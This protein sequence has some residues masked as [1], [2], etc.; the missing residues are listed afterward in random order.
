MSTHGKP[1]EDLL[2]H[3]S[4][5]AEFL[6]LDTHT[7]AFNKLKTAICKDVTL[8]YF[9]SSLPTY[10][11]CEKGIGVVMLQ[12][13]STIKNTSKSDVPHNFCPVFYVSK[14][15]TDT[16]SNY[17]NIEHEMLGVVFSILHF[18]HFTFGWKVRVITDHKPLITLFRKNLHS[19]SPRLSRMLVQILDYNIEFHHQEG[20]KM[21]L[22]NALSRLNTHDSNAEKSEAKPVADFNITIHDVEILTGLKSLSL[23][24]IQRETECDAD[25]QL[26]KQH[27]SDGFPKAKSCLP[28]SIPSFYDYR[29]CLSIVDGVIMKGHCVIIPAS[30]RCK[31]LE[32]LHLSHMGIIKT[33][34]CARTAI[35][36]PN[37]Q[38]DIIT[39]L[40]SCHPCAEF[41]I[42]QKPEP[43]SHDVPMVAWHSLTL[44]NF[45]FKGTHYLL[46]Y[47]RFS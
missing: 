31:T 15:L 6:W 7:E 11:E 17:S 1:L 36:W 26:L 47:D 12:P 29:E 28:E 22:S 44:D 38:K 18:K 20:T 13:D 8:K 39:Y 45:E 5:D 9:D 21:H 23:D 19:T 35:F 3:S 32:T 30:L 41:K 25:M 16:E 27:I 46:V 42:K 10:I 14:T 2:K 24:Q 33:V 43:L 34:E 4:V 37:M 40:S